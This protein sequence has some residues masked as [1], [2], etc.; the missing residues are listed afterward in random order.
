MRAFI[1]AKIGLSPFVLFW[2]LA[3]AAPRL[4]VWAALGL[5]AVL[6]LW[7]FARGAPKQVEVAGLVLFA[8]LAALALAA[9]EWA[10]AHG[11]PLSFLGAALA[12]FVSLARDK[13]WTA[14]YAAASHPGQAESPIFIG[15]NKALSSLW[16][17]I[18]AALG[19]LVWLHAPSVASLVLTLAGALLSIFGP[20]WLVRAVLA[21]KIAAQRGFDWPA[22][23]FRVTRADGELDVAIIGAGLGGLAAAA[24]LSAKGLKVKVFEQH[25]VPG[26]YCHSWLR[27][28]QHDGAPRL[29]RF[30]AGPHDFS[31]AFPGG[32]LDRLLNR[33]GC[34]DRIE[35][36]RLDHRFIRARGEIFDPPRDWRAHA[37]ALANLYPGDA[38]GI[39]AVFEVMKALF[40]PISRPARYF[41]GPPPSVDGMLDFARKNPVFVQWAERPFVDLLDRH[42]RGD[43]ARTALLALI[44]YISDDASAPRC[45][46]M[47][48][49]FGYYFEGGFY[50]RGGTSRFAETLAESIAA[51]GGALACKTAVAKILVENGRACGL[52]L[53]SGEI[54]RAR[55]VVANSDPRKTFLE[56]L[57]AGD[58]PATFREKIEA[59]PPAVSGF[60]VHL[61]VKGEWDGRPLTFVAG[62]PEIL[63]ARPGLVDPSDA[64]EGYSA[65]D[66]L[67]LLPHDKAKDWLPPQGGPDW[68]DWRRS[69]DY[70]AR[71]QAMAETMIAQA[72]KALPGLRD[73]IVLRC[74][75][76]PLTY[77][78]YDFS[79]AGAIYGIAPQGRMRG[80]KSPIPGLF[81]AGA[82]NLG[83]GVEAAVLSGIW[84]AEA[85]APGH[86]WGRRDARPAAPARSAEGQLA[87]AD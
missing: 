17:A 72:E 26:G 85:I 74:E 4:A 61:A 3:P 25:V 62:D 46:E 27:K 86:D 50:P 75:A 67:T 47:A 10:A 28:A 20:N 7:Q 15:I 58:L 63:I 55:A 9:R 87:T 22:P 36:L 80:S 64:P 32:N 44:G 6:N 69:P 77:A 31:G 49:I 21:R 43:G 41:S 39:V 73:R 76:S 59:A 68:R 12:A 53:E 13:P 16:M 14:D 42:I 52:R 1:G 56:L 71:K 23:D 19:L 45:A 11:L 24:V 83:P 84:A 30:D 2:A 18:F 35:W 57:D 70:L 54:V 66:L 82:I 81:V 38:D 60:G 78:R 51:H 29:F 5:S 33:L 79:S 34:A 65:I 40:D 37:R 8:A 48:P